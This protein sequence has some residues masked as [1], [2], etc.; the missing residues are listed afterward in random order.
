MNNRDENDDDHVFSSST[1]S[2]HPNTAGNLLIRRVEEQTVNWTDP[3][4][5][6]EVWNELVAIFPATSEKRCYIPF[7]VAKDKLTSVMKGKHGK[8]EDFDLSLFKSL[9]GCFNTYVMTGDHTANTNYI[10]LHGT[11][12]SLQLGLLATWMWIVR[13]T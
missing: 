5:I 7:A 2:D 1:V 4:A 3:R 8:E 9:R 11:W 12:T 6:E 10:F 13:M